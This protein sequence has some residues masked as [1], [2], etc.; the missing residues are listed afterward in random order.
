MHH[1]NQRLSRRKAAHHLLADSLFFDPGDEFLHHGQGDVGFQQS[2]ANLAQ[3]F[4]YVGFGQAGFA[5]EG[6]DYS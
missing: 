4:L 6:L 3:S 5:P 1:T 2:H